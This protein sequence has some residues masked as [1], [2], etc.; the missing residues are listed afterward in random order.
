MGGGGF[1]A[2]SP[3][4]FGF[5]NY[6]LVWVVARKQNIQVEGY[7]CELDG[8]EVDHAFVCSTVLFDARETMF[9]SILCMG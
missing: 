5:M 6:F 8:I 2:M 9:R 7:S 1:F 3:I 4:L